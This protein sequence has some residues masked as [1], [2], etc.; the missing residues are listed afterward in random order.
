V[1]PLSALGADEARGLRGLLFD[2]DDTLLS[3]GSLTLAAYDALWRLHDAGLILVAVTGRPCGWG[4]VFVRQWPISGCI[5]ENGAVWVLRRGARAVRREGCDEAERGARR[6]RLGQL[7][8]RVRVVAPD[9]EL[10]DDAAARRSDVTWDIGENAKLPEERVRIIVREIESAGA[11]WS[12][13]SVHLHATFDVDDKAS[14]AVRFCA[15]ELG[16]DPGSAVVRFA[17][18]GDSQNDG[19]CFAA[20][21][22]TFGV[23]NVR[24]S[25]PR[26]SVPPRYAAARSMGEGFADVA[27][28]IL[29]KRG[30]PPRTPVC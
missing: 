20:F 24:S 17:F 13:S 7:V 6:V 21:K 3:H 16:E 9:A 14:G 15:R 25:V 10:T 4:E 23:A 1:K 26:L 11:R 12:Q 8:E 22:T 29:V 19:P 30:S 27:S 18:I 5:V 28:E 2:L